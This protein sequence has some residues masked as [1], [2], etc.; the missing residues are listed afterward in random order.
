MIG[1]NFIDKYVET[2]SEH[3]AKNFAW[4]FLDVTEKS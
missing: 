2:F 4:K 3:S 1:R